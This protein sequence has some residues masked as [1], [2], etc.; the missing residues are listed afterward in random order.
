MHRLPCST[1]PCSLIFL[2]SDGLRSGHFDR[3]VSFTSPGQTPV[4]IHG[5]CASLVEA[6]LFYELDE[7]DVLPRYYDVGART[8]IFI[9]SSV[10]GLLPKVLQYEWS[11][12]IHSPFGV[13]LTAEC[14]CVSKNINRYWVNPRTVDIHCKNCALKWSR[15]IP[16]GWHWVW[17]EQYRQQA[18]A[19]LVFS[20][21][22]SKRLQPQV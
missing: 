16:E 8:G 12:P 9:I 21:S 14:H 18:Y 20:L 10:H 1:I 5:L 17:Q 11:H 2:Y 22:V 7:L 3:I 15:S 6:Y 4:H 13:S 19:W